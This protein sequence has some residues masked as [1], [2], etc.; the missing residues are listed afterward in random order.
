[1][2]GFGPRRR[3]MT[4]NSEFLQDVRVSRRA[5]QAYIE[6]ARDIGTTLAKGEP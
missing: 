3:F 6:A 4:F 2:K 5:L 1:M